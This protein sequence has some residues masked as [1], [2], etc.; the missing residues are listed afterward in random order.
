MSLQPLV[1]RCCL[2][3]VFKTTVF[4]PPI[5]IQQA[6][7]SPANPVSVPIRHPSDKSS[8]VSKLGDIRIYIHRKHKIPGTYAVY[9]CVTCGVCGLF[10]WNMAPGLFAFSS[11]QLAL[12][13][14]HGPFFCLLHAIFPS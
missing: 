7:T 10:S 1:P 3:R 12:T 9:S 5:A 2:L 14:K 11:R 8:V 6:L 4:F 13:I